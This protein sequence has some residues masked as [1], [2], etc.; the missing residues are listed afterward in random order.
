ME[1]IQLTTPA[2]IAAVA[3]LLIG[4][5]P[6]ESIL[7]LSLREPRGRLGRTMR[8]DLPP[9]EADEALA[10]EIVRRLLVDRATRAA[11]VIYTE[12]A[13]DGGLPRAALAALLEQHFD[14]AGLVTKEM[15]LVRDG[16]WWS[17]LCSRPDCCPPGGTPLTVTDAASRTAAEQILHGSVVLSSREDLERSLDFT[18]PLGPAVAAEQLAAADWACALEV[19]ERGV[20][21]V[22]RDSLAL[23]QTALSRFAVPPAVVGD[24]EWAELVARLSDRRVRDRVLT[25]V[26]D[27]E[28]ALVGLLHALVRRTPAPYDADV[29]GLLAWIAALRGEGAL[30]NVALDRAL[31]SEPDH[32]MCTLLRTALDGQVEGRV[33]RDLVDQTRRVIDG[34]PASR[35]D[36]RGNRTSRRRR[37]A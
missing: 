29:C 14:A 5:V 24:L 21:T 16:R 31:R 33:L 7:L 9:P 10:D 6:S 22:R 19:V 8:Y 32:G 36:R 1:L 20:E 15:L 13:D 12:A 30:A 35:A 23:W 34:A 37:A 4:F 25:E 2:D 27:R 18:G 17:Y 3:P 11:V 26:L 28:D